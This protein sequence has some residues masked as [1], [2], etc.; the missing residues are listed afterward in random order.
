MHITLHTRMLLAKTMLLRENQRLLVE[1]MKLGRS[2]IR[3][4]R[5]KILWLREAL[6]NK[7]SKSSS[8]S[9]GTRPCVNKE[10]G[11][12]QTR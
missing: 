3:S 11:S 8:I 5:L 2:H 7:A 1:K 9:G 6:L 4:K 12:K 10:A